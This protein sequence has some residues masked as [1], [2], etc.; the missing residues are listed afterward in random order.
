MRVPGGIRKLV[1][2]RHTFDRLLVGTQ[3]DVKGPAES[4]HHSVARDDL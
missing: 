2:E 4:A 1:E 3:E